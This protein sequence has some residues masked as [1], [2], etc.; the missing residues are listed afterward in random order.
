MLLGLL[1]ATLAAAPPPQ[2]EAPTVEELRWQVRPS[3]VEISK[4][5][6]RYAQEGD[7]RRAKR[8]ADAVLQFRRGLTGHDGL[9]YLD[10]LAAALERQDRRQVEQGLR[11]LIRTDLRFLLQHLCDDSVQEGAS[12]R[13]RLLMA[14][15]DLEYLMRWLPAGKE[16]ERNRQLLLRIFGKLTEVVPGKSSYQQQD[17]SW[18]ADAEELA[19]K[20]ELALDA[21]FP[22]LAAP[23]P[24]EGSEEGSR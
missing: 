18:Q 8:A 1:L 22:A 14:K 15:Q 20:L 2:Q 17:L 11:V 13:T 5:V 23:P 16:Q 19:G 4:R 10:P 7:F 21:I 6:H 24:E 3:M 12:P 9:V